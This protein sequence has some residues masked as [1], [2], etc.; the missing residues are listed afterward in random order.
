MTLQ[1]LFFF[2]GDDVCELLQY[3]RLIVL[4]F[5]VVDYPLDK[6]S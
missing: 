3:M 2:L 4:K 5:I 6:H 1:R